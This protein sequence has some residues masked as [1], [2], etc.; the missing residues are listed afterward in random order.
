MHP[1]DLYPFITLSTL[2]LSII[3]WCFT[4]VIYLKG[5]FFQQGIYYILLL[6]LCFR[7]MIF[8]IQ[9]SINRMIT[10][11]TLMLSRECCFVK[12]F[13]F[14]YMSSG[15]VALQPHLIDISTGWGLL[16]GNPCIFLELHPFTMHYE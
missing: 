15:A 3:F 1:K 14:V 6:N 16:L 10:T 12:D 8:Y 5:Y 11:S 7:T 2:L 13:C 9:P 4:E